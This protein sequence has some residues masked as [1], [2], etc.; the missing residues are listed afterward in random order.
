ML[1]RAQPALSWALNALTGAST[2]L[3]VD[4]DYVR[5]DAGMGRFRTYCDGGCECGVTELNGYV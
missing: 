1:L 4:L 5:T 3:G 2:D